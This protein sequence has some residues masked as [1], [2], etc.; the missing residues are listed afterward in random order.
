M[1]KNIIFLITI[2]FFFLN[3]S[4]LAQSKRENEESKFGIGYAAALF[5]FWEIDL[6]FKG[7]L[8]DEISVEGLIGIGLEGPSEDDEYIFHG[9]G[10]KVSYEFT[11]SSKFNFYGYS[12]L[13]YLKGSKEPVKK[14]LVG[15]D[16]FGLIVGLGTESWNGYYIEGGYIKMD[17]ISSFTIRLGKHYYF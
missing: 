17:H 14:L 5:G 7:Y 11:R 8:S 2:C 9:L 13:W 6:N 16:F 4:L 12:T 1:I 10:T 3:V 15:K